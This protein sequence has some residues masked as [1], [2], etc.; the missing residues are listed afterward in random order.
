MEGLQPSP[1]ADRYALVRRLYLD[2]IGLPPTPEEADAFVKD[3]SEN[4]YERLVDRLLA[5]PQYGER[6]ARVWLDLARYAD[7]SGYTEDSDRSM[8]PYRDWVVR[9]LNADTPFDRFTIQQ[10][11]G[12]LLPNA[13]LDDR[14]ATGF[15]RNTML[16][17]E[18]GVDPLEYR[19]YAM[20]D[21]VNTTSTTWLGLT[22]G[23]AQCHTHKYDPIPQRDYYS[24]LALMN[25]TEEPELKVPDP[26]ITEQRQEIEAQIASIEAKMRKRFS[27]ED[28]A[29]R[30]ESWRGD[31]ATR[32]M[33]WKTVQP[34]K[35]TSEVPILS[36]MEDGSV[37]A[38]GDQ[39]TRDHYLVELGTDLRGVTA[40]RLEAIPDDRLPKRG[41]GRAYYETRNGDFFLSEMTLQANGE[42][43]KFSRVLP[44]F[45]ENRGRNG[46][47]AGETRALLS[48]DGD[49][50]TGWSIATRVGQTS[51]VVF[52][53]EKPLDDASKLKL[54]LSFEVFHPADL[55][56]FRISATNDPIPEKINIL[57]ID[58]DA[59]IG[60]SARQARP[61][62]SRETA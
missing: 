34:T 60:G 61:R 16:N 30:F 11:A 55:G 44:T 19:F 9:S 41:P 53:L 59:L 43:V 7:T 42:P 40:I 48:V 15:H 3:E 31:A 54:E 8:W 35:A 6:W 33:H 56:R 14:I 27:P 26:V 62:R 4:A 51:A 58:I 45:V 28:L 20:V 32:A 13:T 57:P 37:F 5:S 50:Q 12:D 38:T 36:I 18:D 25:N 47:F 22:L 21:R 49:Q 1:E 10:I 23:C 46:P 29:S 17:D 24:F 2:L 52:Q 39:T